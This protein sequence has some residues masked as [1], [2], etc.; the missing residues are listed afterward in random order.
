MSNLKESKAEELL[1]DSKVK[2]FMEMLDDDIKR[3]DGEANRHKDMYRGVRTAVIVLSAITTVVAGAG[4]V[5]PD[6]RNFIQFF[7]LTLS[8]GATATGSWGE[9]RRAQE[10]WQHERALHRALMDIRQEIKFKCIIYG[11]LN[12][13]QAEY[14]FEQVSSV[15]G[16]SVDRWSGILRREQPASTNAQGDDEGKH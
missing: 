9:M 13:T 1:Q 12:T 15:L 4:L 14:Y 16:P 3:L 11:G 5:F 7:V 10:I 6:S 8:A 2:E